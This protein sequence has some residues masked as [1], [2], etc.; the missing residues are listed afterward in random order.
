MSLLAERDARVL[1]ATENFRD[2]ASEKEKQRRET[3]D[4]ESKRERERER[5][6]ERQSQSQS[7]SQNRVCQRQHAEKD[8]RVQ[9]RN[10]FDASCGAMHIDMTGPCQLLN[11]W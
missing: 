11:G 2:H 6:R 4:T 5:E 8:L 9:Q 3:G 10:V 1:P 7:Q